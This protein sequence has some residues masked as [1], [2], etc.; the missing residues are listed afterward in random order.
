MNM[1]KSFPLAAADILPAACGFARSGTCGADGNNLTW[2]LSNGTLTI[3]GTGH[4]RDWAYYSGAPWKGRNITQ[5]KIEDGVTSIGEYVFYACPALVSVTIPYGVTSIGNSAFARCPSLAS[6]A[7]PDSVTRIG[8]FAF[9]FCHGLTSVT[10]PSGVT[11]IGDEPFGSCAGLTAIEVEKDNPSYLS[12]NGVL[13]NR[14][15]T[16][17]IQYPA[18][19]V[20]GYVIPDGVT[21]IEWFAFDSFEDNDGFAI[22]NLRSVTIPES[23][24][25]IGFAGFYH[26]VGLAHVIVKNNTPPKCEGMVFEA[27][28]PETCVLH[29]PAG[30]KSL[31]QNAPEWRHFVT[32]AEDADSFSAIEEA[33]KIKN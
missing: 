6:I 10:V 28:P 9:S 20:G 8:D 25:E 22:N 26:C 27:V 12:E 16:V 4:M 13:F 1:K 15:K 21:K 31:Y 7:I 24:T 23:V 29:V 2:S 3:S 18:G 30:G 19:R 17:L 14:E 5:V 11:S 32:V 33:V